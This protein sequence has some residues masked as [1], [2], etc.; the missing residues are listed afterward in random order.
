VPP[1]AFY[2]PFVDRENQNPASAVQVIASRTRAG[3][4]YGAEP[5]RASLGF[6]EARAIASHIS[7]F[8][9]STFW[10]LQPDP[11]G[12]GEESGQLAA[13]LAAVALDWEIPYPLGYAFSEFWAT[14][15]FETDQTL[16]Q[17]I[18][19][20]TG[21][22]IRRKIG[23][24]MTSESGRI[25]FLPVSNS[26]FLLH[27]GLNALTVGD[28]SLKAQTATYWLTRKKTFV[29]VGPEEVP[30]IAGALF[31]KTPRNRQRPLFASPEPV[32]SISIRP[33]AELG[34]STV[35]PTPTRSLPEITE[36]VSGPHEGPSGQLPA[37]SH[38]KRSSRRPY[39]FL[40]IFSI[41]A[42]AIIAIIAGAALVGVVIDLLSEKEVVTAPSR[43]LGSSKPGREPDSGSPVSTATS[44]LPSLP[45]ADPTS[46]VES[47]PTVATQ[48]LLPSPTLAGS[49]PVEKTRSKPTSVTSNQAPS[50]TV[51]NAPLV[52]TRPQPRDESTAR[53]PIY[54]PIAATNRL[55]PERQDDWMVRID[56]SGSRGA[57]IESARKNVYPEL[58]RCGNRY[59]VKVQ[60]C[61]AREPD[62]QKSGSVV[63]KVF[64][65]GLEFHAAHNIRSCLERSPG[66]LNKDE[67]HD[68]TQAKGKQCLPILDLAGQ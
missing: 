56:A 41:I 67:T 33:S 16:S 9:N 63:F 22:D 12:L 44:S 46:R 54:S 10:S 58:K 36:S 18:E 19:D 21:G 8:H 65:A 28:F 62:G 20:D 52:V 50:P 55:A 30:D 26:S 4:F 57:L 13:C 60:L 48:N 25:F 59:R 27:Q 47:R 64:A 37:R 35:A 66:L 49:D 68:V 34:D 38:A 2:F 61:L 31:G 51:A 45:G 5:E 24:F 7:G 40:A 14:G 43:I 39:Y 3:A 15:S 53:K 32:A 1:L 42:I 11:V 29:V 23:G 6:L 17:R